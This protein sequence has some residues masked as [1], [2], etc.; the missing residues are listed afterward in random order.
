MNELF[1]S[2]D[3]E[4]DGPIPGEYSMLS[5][6]ACLVDN[7]SEK[8]YIEF[9]P[10]SDNHVQE[11]LTCNGLNIA[12]LEKHGLTPHEGMNTIDRWLKAVSGANRP[13]VVVPFISSNASCIILK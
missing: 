1:I 11:A 4:T 9:K 8:I 10:I 13:V 2:V 7:P 3:I 6:G 5:F 12:M